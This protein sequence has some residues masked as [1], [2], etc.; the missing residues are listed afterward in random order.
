MAY[1]GLTK[2]GSTVLYNGPKHHLLVHSI[3]RVTCVPNTIS[4]SKK[5]LEWNVGDS[6]P[7]GL[8]PLPGTL[9][10]EPESYIEGGTTPVFQR[11]QSIEVVRNIWRDLKS[12]FFFICVVKVLH[13][14][15]IYNKG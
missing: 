2:M 9:M 13:I 12:C 3:I 15:Y 11:V 1:S 4:P 8:Q 7:H 6:F 10:K 5:H 14:M